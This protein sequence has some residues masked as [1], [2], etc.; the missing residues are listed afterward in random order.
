MGEEF[1]EES[2]RRDMAGPVVQTRYMD[3][4]ESQKVSHI[5]GYAEVGSCQLP[6]GGVW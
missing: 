3:K 4:T 6:G 1:G 2:S 5:Y